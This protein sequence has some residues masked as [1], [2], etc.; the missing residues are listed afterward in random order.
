[1]DHDHKTGKVRGLLCNKCNLILGEYEK[2]RNQ[3]DNYLTNAINNVI[4]N[5]IKVDT[6]KYK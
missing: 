5:P 4:T 2:Y 3:I 1:M 6:D